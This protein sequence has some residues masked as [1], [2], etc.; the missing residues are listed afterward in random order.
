MNKIRLIVLSFCLWSFWTQAAV[1]LDSPLLAVDSLPELDA[2]ANLKLKDS[3]FLYDRM[4]NPFGLD[5][6]LSPVAGSLRFGVNPY[7]RLIAL[8]NPVLPLDTNFAVSNIS[9]VLG[10]TREQLLFLDHHQHIT[11]KL[12]ATISYH[13][14]V[15]PG[16][17]LNC[18][19][20]YRRFSSS[21]FFNSSWVNSSFNFT[22]SKVDAD[23]NGGIESDQQ[24]DGRS[25][26]DY[27]QLITN[28][29]DDNRE[30]RKYLVELKNAVKLFSFAG[31][32]STSSNS[33]LFN[34]DV[35]WQKWGTR[36][37][38]LADK[39]FYSSFFLDTASTNDTSGYKYLAYRPGLQLKHKGE[40]ISWN[41]YSSYSLYQLELRLDSL[42][43]TDSYYRWTSGGEIRFGQFIASAEWNLISGDAFNKDDRSLVA[44]LSWNKPSAF[45]SGISVSTGLSSLSP[46]WTKS[47]YISNH[48]LWSNDFEK[49]QLSWVYLNLS[50]W[51]NRISL[52]HHF[53]HADNYCY[54]NELALPSQLKQQFQL[55]RVGV[56]SDVQWKKW[57]LISNV[58]YALASHQV[59]RLPEWAAYVRGSYQTSFFKKAL[60]AEFGAAV[61]VT[62]AWKNYA[63]MPATGALYLQQEVNTGG[64]PTLDLFVNADIGKATIT[65]MFQRVNAAWGQTSYYIAPGYP[66]APS[67]IKF[68]LNWP[69]VN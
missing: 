7:E 44:G 14:V 58:R 67:T 27:E 56:K 2:F 28:L 48:F 42:K 51:K 1:K 68:G 33:V 64:K 61:H 25:R 15:S 54:F 13:S 4:V 8:E 55:Q 21:L 22:Y 11:K 47:N 20:V 65:L 53:Q 19:S 35:E 36:Y 62:Q 31:A 50:I 16:F 34:A 10:S 49:E 26:T 24:L 38:G 5:S 39:D 23:E 69:L 37:T 18:L 32:D 43:S 30:T 12:S 9:V 57:R 66:V 29:S 6:L 45:V 63:F 52:F 17:V 3:P 41:V 40:K 59:I 46:D 60:K